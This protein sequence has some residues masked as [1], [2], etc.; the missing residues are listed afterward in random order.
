[1]KDSTSGLSIAVLSALLL[2]AGPVLI[3]SAPA[4]ATGD[5]DDI[6]ELWGDQSDGDQDETGWYEPPPPVSLGYF[7]SPDGSTVWEHGQTDVL[8]EWHGFEGDTVRLEL[9]GDGERIADLKPWHP[10]EG[11]F[12]RAAPVAGTWGS[13]RHFQVRILD[14]E[15][16]SLTSEEFLILAPF[17]VITPDSDTRWAHEERDVPVSWTSIDGNTV[18]IE[19]VNSLDLST[20]AV[21]S[22][23]TLNTGSFIVPEVSP[24]W[25]AGAGYTVKITDNLGNFTYGDPFNICGVKV[26]QPS[27]GEPWRIGEVPPDIV[28]SCVGTIVNVELWEEG[29]EAPLAVLAEWVPNSGSVSFDSTF[30][31]SPFELEKRYYIRVVNDLEQTGLSEPFAAVYSDNI[32]EGAVAL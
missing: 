5:E 32:P 1:M 11:F 22:E 25:G 31:F 8:I 12:V 10:S 26:E 4:S 6:D 9:L 2:A 30:D 27:G 18:M 29:G 14:Q 13:G 23:G 7:T 15:G 28:W 20:I 24:D 16:N 21:L 3:C 19:L 17:S